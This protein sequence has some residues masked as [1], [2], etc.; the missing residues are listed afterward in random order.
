MRSDLPTAVRFSFEQRPLPVP[1]DLRIAWRLA[2]V[3]LA[4]WHSRGNRASL[5][6]LHM[7]SHAVRFEGAQERLRQ[8]V[9]GDKLA[10]S[11]RTTVEPAL[12][13]AIDFVVGEGLAEWTQIAKRAGL[14]LTANGTD[15]VSQLLGEDELM[16]PEKDMIGTLAPKLTE[17]LVTNALAAKGFQI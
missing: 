15:S 2:V 3:L 11:W 8:I 16:E 5:A 14:Q 12:G 1:G 17:G 13:R 9:L 6:K 4:L 7:L 10:G